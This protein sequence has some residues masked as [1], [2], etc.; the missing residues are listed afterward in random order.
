MGVKLTCTKCHKEKSYKEFYSCDSREIG[1]MWNCKEC[2]K[3]YQKTYKRRRTEEGRSIERKPECPEKKSEFNRKWYKENSA[4]HKEY[5]KQNALKRSKNNRAYE[6]RNP[7]RV[8][9]QHAL[10][11]ALKKGILVRPN[12]CLVC[13]TKC[14]P[15]GHH[16]DYTK[17]L[18]VVWV[19]RSCHLEI[20]RKHHFKERSNSLRVRIEKK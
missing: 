8:K 19:C 1:R 12:K 5:Y 16:N 2:I 13:A 17:Q 20:H 14:K 7:E 11:R 15:E 10:Y 6:K 4:Y 3:A 9:A 18:E